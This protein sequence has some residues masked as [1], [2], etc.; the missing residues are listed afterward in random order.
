MTVSQ[1]LSRVV[2]DQISSLRA[3][4]LGDFLHQSLASIDDEMLVHIWNWARDFHT[5][6]RVMSP[7]AIFGA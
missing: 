4:E 2:A 1:A 5:N 6:W 3:R 7:S